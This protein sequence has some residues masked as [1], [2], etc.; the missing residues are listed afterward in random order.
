[1]D[2][3]I[4]AAFNRLPRPELLMSGRIVAKNHWYFSVLPFPIEGCPVDTEMIFFVNPTTSEVKIHGPAY[5]NSLTPDFDFMTMY[6][7][8]KLFRA[9]SR[10]PNH[11]FLI[12]GTEGPCCIA[13]FTWSTSSL[14]MA[15]SMRTQLEELDVY[16]ELC[17][18][19]VAP[20][21][22]IN[23]VNKLYDSLLKAAMRLLELKTSPGEDG[24]C[25]RDFFSSKFYKLPDHSASDV[26]TDTT[27]DERA[28]MTCMEC[29][30]TS[31]LKV[32]GRCQ[33]A[34]YCSKTCQRAHWKTIHKYECAR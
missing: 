1:M 26:A 10:F 20:S 25:A 23:A 34:W 21:Y 11:R 33:L 14:A 31:S 32:C 15:M 3:G 12:P 5:I 4:L 18:V 30:S 16:P 2:S 28:Y 9:F 8:S 22:L 7:I 29:G 13:P 19:K 17:K 6:F 27:S 24:D